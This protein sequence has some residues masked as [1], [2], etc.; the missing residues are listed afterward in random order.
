MNR[1]T[2]NARSAIRRIVKG[3]QSPLMHAQE[4]GIKLL[5]KQKLQKGN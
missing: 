3:S 4:G 5:T 1:K 2:V